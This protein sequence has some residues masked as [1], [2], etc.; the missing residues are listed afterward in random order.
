MNIDRMINMLLLKLS[1]KQ[2]IFYMEKRNYIN[3]KV[4]KSYIISIKKQSE[5]FKSKRELLLYLKEL[6]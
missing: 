6:I 3:G 5:E 1:E 2:N 4:Y